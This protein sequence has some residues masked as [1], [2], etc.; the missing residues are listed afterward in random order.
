MIGPWSIRC[1]LL[2]ALLVAPSEFNLATSQTLY[3]WVDEKG[4]THYSE[5]PPP[6]KPSKA[7]TLPPSPATPGAT[8]SQKSGKTTEQLEAEFQQRQKAR[9]A[10]AARESETIQTAEKARQ[11]KTRRCA[12]AKARIERL[13]AQRRSQLVLDQNRLIATERSNRAFDEQGRE[14]NRLGKYVDENCPPG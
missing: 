8:P 1:A 12:E 10:N 3:R 2:I 4:T 9:D 13:Q 5:T 6:R 7:L 14:L 11:E